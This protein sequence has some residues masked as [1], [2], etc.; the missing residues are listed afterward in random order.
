MVLKT[1]SVAETFANVFISLDGVSLLI[2]FDEMV[3]EFLAVAVIV[4]FAV[5]LYRIKMV[6]LSVPPVKANVVAFVST[7][8]PDTLGL[9][10]DDAAVTVRVQVFEPN[11]VL[12]L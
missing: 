12:P 8:E 10:F 2:D 4:H 3:A 11:D 7:T 9:Q 5:D 1:N 6:L